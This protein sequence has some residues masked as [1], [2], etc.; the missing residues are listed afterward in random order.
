M[1]SPKIIF[2]LFV[3]FAGVMAQAKNEL[4][5]F[6]P[7]MQ[8]RFED[9]QEQVRKNH[10]YQN[11]NISGIIFDDYLVGLEFNQFK[12]SSGNSSLGVTQ[13]FRE[14]NLYAGYFFYSQLVDSKRSIVLDL[15]PNL[16]LGQNYFDT[17]TYL[18]SSVVEAKGEPNFVFA[19]GFQ[20]TLRIKFIMLQADFRYAYSRV[21]Q[22]SYTPIYGVRLG[23]RIAL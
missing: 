19:A 2:I 22:P 10:R 5:F 17:E 12:Q 20:G 15:G 21:Y 8:F 4:H 13:K 11:Y 23:F 16:Y 18:G 3:F 9:D 1:N 14:F 7:G 6:L